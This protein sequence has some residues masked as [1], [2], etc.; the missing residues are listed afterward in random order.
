MS[1]LGRSCLQPLCPSPVRRP[2]LQEPPGPRSHRPCHPAVQVQ[3]VAGLGSCRWGSCETPARL[4][5][6]YVNERRL[7]FLNKSYFKQGSYK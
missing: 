7:F 6:G 3:G 5:V 4:S 2:H 1:G